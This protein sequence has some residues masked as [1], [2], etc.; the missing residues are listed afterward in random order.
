MHL[1]Y[2]KYLENEILTLENRCKTL[3]ENFQEC[4]KDLE[5]VKDFEY[6]SDSLETLE[7][8]L[9]NENA[10]LENM[11]NQLEVCESSQSKAHAT[12]LELSESISQ[13]HIDSNIAEKKLKDFEEYIVLSNEDINN[14]L[15]LNHVKDSLKR[16]DNAIQ[17]L[18]NTC[19]KVSEN[20]MGV[21]KDCAELKASIT[22][23]SDKAS[24][25]AHYIES[26]IIDKPLE[27]LET[28]YRIL[29]SEVQRQKSDYENYCSQLDKEVSKEKN[30]LHNDYPDLTL[31]DYNIK[32]DSS[33]L[34]QLK[35]QLEQN[36]SKLEEQKINISTQKSTVSL[37]RK[38]LESRENAL[39]RSGLE[40]PLDK[41]KILSNYDARENEYKLKITNATQLEK[42]LST[43]IRSLEVDEV[44][45]YHALN[46]EVSLLDSVEEV[47]E[48]VNVK[49]LCTQ[50]KTLHDELKTQHRHVLNTFND[51]EQLHTNDSDNTINQILKSVCIDN[52]STYLGCCKVS[53]RLDTIQQGLNS[54]IA[55]LEGI[56]KHFNDNHKHV[57]HQVYSHAKQLYEQVLWIPKH[58]HVNFN[59]I[60][61]RQTLELD[62]PK[63]LDNQAETRI[64]NMVNSVFTNLRNSK[65]DDTTE[66]IKENF[67]NRAMFNAI[68]NTSM[69]NIRVYKVRQ[70][71][72][73]TLERWESAYSGGERFLAYF[74]VYSA[75]TTYTRSRTTSESCDKTRSVFLIDN[76]FGATSSTHLLQALVEITSRFN[77]QLVCFSDLKQSSITNSFDLIYQLSLKRATYGEKFYLTMDNVTGNSADKLTHSLEHVYLKQLQL[78]D[79]L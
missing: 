61:K 79:F 30:V 57:V 76:P 26:E 1:T 14:L 15:E 71:G 34:N 55:T 40:Y 8:N 50:Y 9:Q 73:N 42:S 64:E 10:I 56:L 38:H 48:L 36:S 5:S 74:I 27:Q 54:Q 21:N 52:I 20:I 49:S 66:Y 78:D 7:R 3:D 46:V 70:D 11:Q 51:L 59:G 24:Q 58:S 37:Y 17:D 60:G 32:F 29:I 18:E 75:L 23:Y 62:I 47:T 28:Q 35:E 12:L 77:L 53:E 43:E 63:E 69:V 33:K 68:T 13:K 19:K 41:S 16:V 31:N 39:K 67:S 6:K 4:L 22:I 25:Y 44:S 72:T 45:L 65:T 2:G